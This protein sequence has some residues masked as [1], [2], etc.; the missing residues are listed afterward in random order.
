MAQ[1]NTN[2]KK[3]HHIFP[4]SLIKNNSNAVP[5]TQLRNE[6]SFYS[7][8]FIIEM[9]KKMITKLLPVILPE[10]GRRQSRFDFEE[11]GKI[12]NLLKTQTISNFTYTY[13]AIHKI[14][15]NLQNHP[16]N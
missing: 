1:K 6:I 12:S 13:P 5:P 8:T 16:V 7:C 15:L 14:S 10:L 9:R 3:I 2:D 11:F 4:H